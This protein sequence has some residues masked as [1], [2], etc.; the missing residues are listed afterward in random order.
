M[1]LLTHTGGVGPPEDGDSLPLAGSAVGDEGLTVAVFMDRTLTH[2]RHTRPTES[3][4]IIDITVIKL[5][6]SAV[7]RF[8]NL[9]YGLWV[10]GMNKSN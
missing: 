9:L 5:S 4:T 6:V 7:P 3:R 10:R 8:H 2:V 1:P